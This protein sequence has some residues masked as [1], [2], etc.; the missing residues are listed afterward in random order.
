VTRAIILVGNPARPYSRALRIG[1][2]LVAAGLDV[3]IAATW[4]DG[5]PEREDEGPI[6]V[7]RYRPVGRMAGHSARNRPAEERRSRSRWRV[8]RVFR[9]RRARIVEWLF[10]PQ[11]VRGWWA[12][13]GRDLPAA[14]I[15]HACGLLALP[16]ALAAR[17]RDRKAGRQSRVIYDVIDITLE[18]NNVATLPPLVR[19]LLGL[20]ERRWARGADA[21]TAVN[22]PFGDRAVER[23]QL[24][25]RPTVVPNYPLP[26]EEPAIRPDRIRTE[27]G[28]APA[29]RVCLFWGRIG[30]NLG[31]EEAAE[32]V[33]L[34]EDAV[35]VVIGFG[36]G[37]DASRSRDVEGRFA[38]R[39]F[40]LPARHPDE[41]LEW[42]ASADVALITLPPISFNQRFT[43]PNKF[44][45]AMA[46]GTPIVLGPD[47]PTMSGILATEDL[48]RVASSMA[49]ADI[50]SAIRSIL[51]LPAADRIAWRSRI[52][53]TARRD[54]SW[55]R[56][57]EPYRALVVDLLGRAGLQ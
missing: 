15:Y 50:A 53:A 36:R 5:A 38:G 29:V 30:L 37:W 6:T 14:D 13:L 54:Y 21:W 46:A 3:E 43:T 57:A 10:W 31:L 19:R 26:W 45:E 4:L 8:V 18:S 28:L 24:P 49:P 39:H 25:V 40:T 56:A 20:R 52:A 33:L 47:L 34:V 16:P 1:R 51:D 32:A 22:V 48:G 35:M 12:A 27:L 7:R 55:P 41:L 42:I 2:T 11:T 9:A 23:W 17:R 44:L